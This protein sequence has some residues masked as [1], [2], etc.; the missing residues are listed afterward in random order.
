MLDWAKEWEI[1]EEMN[2]LLREQDDIGEYFLDVVID[3]RADEG[4]PPLTP[5]ELAAAEKECDENLRRDNEIEAKLDDLRD[6]YFELTGHYPF[7]RNGII[8]QYE[9]WFPPTGR[10]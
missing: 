4:L 10:Q 7:R 1:V 8:P 2:D 9:V 5:E 3:S 6:K